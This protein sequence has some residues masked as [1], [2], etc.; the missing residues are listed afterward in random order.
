[1]DVPHCVINDYNSDT[2]KGVLEFL[3]EN[4]PSTFI[5]YEDQ[6]AAHRMYRFLVENANDDD[7]LRCY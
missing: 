1:M 3:N 5:P 7:L 2:Y 4:I 6:T